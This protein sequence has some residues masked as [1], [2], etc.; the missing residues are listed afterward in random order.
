MTSIT[1]ASLVPQNLPQTS[2]PSARS[3]GDADDAGGSKAIAVPQASNAS[4]PASSVNLSS[5]AQAL[6]GA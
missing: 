1:S 3:D 6:L 4:S 5:A 2:V